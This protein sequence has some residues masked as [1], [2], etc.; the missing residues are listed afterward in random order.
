MASKV[1]TVKEQLIKDIIKI[2]KIGRLPHMSI[3]AQ[4]KL[5]KDWPELAN[6]IERLVKL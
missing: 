5:R 4:R 3:I 2:W 6:A 1:N